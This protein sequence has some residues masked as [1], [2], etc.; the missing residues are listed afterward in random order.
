MKL[1]EKNL[2]KFQ[3]FYLDGVHRQ[4][5]GYRSLAFLVQNPINGK[6]MHLAVGKVKSKDI[7]IQSILYFSR[8]SSM[9]E[10]VKLKE[11]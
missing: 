7:K 1:K 9:K 4:H 8:K 5:K 11:K 3:E 6:L 10:L 2:L